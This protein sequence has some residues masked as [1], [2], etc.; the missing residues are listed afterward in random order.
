MLRAEGAKCNSLGQR[1]RYGQRRFRALKVRNSCEAILH[2]AG[3]LVNR[4]DFAPSALQDSYTSSP[5]A[6]PQAFTFRA[7][8]AASPSL[9]TGLHG[10]G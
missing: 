1:P 3:F 7:F 10:S 6:L 4:R 5:G 9:G 2:A 8:G